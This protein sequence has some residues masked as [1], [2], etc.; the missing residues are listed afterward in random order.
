M[1]T[2][3]SSLPTCPFCD[4]QGLPILPVRYAVARTNLG[5]A[6]SLPPSFGQGVTDIALPGD[7]AKYTLRLLRPGFLYV[8]D[9][10][11][12]EWSA[13]VVNKQSYLWEFDIYAKT[14]PK[15]NNTIE[16]NA[17]CRGKSDPYVA[18]CFTVKRAARATKVWLGF[19]DVAWTQAVLAKHTS[20]DYRQ[21]NM[22]CI[23]IAAWRDGG[24]QPHVTSFDALPQVAE[25]AADGAALYWETR[26]HVMKFLPATHPLPE[27]ITA[28]NDTA[29][30]AFGTLS[31]YV[32][33]LLVGAVGTPHT[34]G[35]VNTAAWKFSPQQLHLSRE[36]T[37]PMTAWGNQSAKPYRPAI[38]GLADPVGI[39]MELNG[40]ALQ[41]GVEFLE[42]PE[43]R[44]QF[45]TVS[46]IDAIHHAVLN[47]AM[48]ERS[49]ANQA[50]A[51][52]TGLFVPHGL[53]RNAGY[54]ETI[55]HN[56]E[57]A[58][59]LSPEQKAALDQEAWP[60][61]EAQL[62]PV[63]W[64]DFKNKY[65]S[66]LQR[67][68]Q[69]IIAP[70]DEAYVAWLKSDG[71]TR[72]FTHNFDDADANHGLIY[73]RVVHAC[74]EQASGRRG[75][76]AYF[77]ECLG[78]DP[79]QP[80]Q[81]ILRAL[82]FNQQKLAMAL[83]QAAIERGNDVD[84]SWREVGEKFYNAVK[85][86]FIDISLGKDIH[87]PLSNL[88][89]LLYQLAGPVTS[90][91]GE[92][93]NDVANMAVSK[94]PERRV[95]ILMM[96]VLHAENPELELLD[97]RSMRSPRQAAK[98]LARAI[99]EVTGGGE[100]NLY[101]SAETLI[102]D[103]THSSQH[104]A[105]GLFLI[106]KRALASLQGADNATRLA[107]VRAETYEALQA[108]S[109]RTIFNAEVK[110][111][112]IGTLF[113][114]ASVIASYRDLVKS[115]DK[116]IKSM[117]FGTSVTAFLGVSMETSGH[118]LEKAP[119][120]E[121]IIQKL[122]TKIG[123][124]AEINAAKLVKL[125]KLLG[126]A[127]GVLAGVVEMWEGGAAWKYDKTYGL[128]MILL[129]IGGA[130]AAALVVFEAFALTGIGLALGLLVIAGTYCIQT[131]KPNEIQKWMARS[132]FGKLNKDQRYADVL[133]Q[134]NTLLKLA[135][136]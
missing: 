73:Q 45:E 42:E 55:H 75:A 110:A 47:G 66:D 28:Y 105:R 125:G 36:E 70:L 99:N 100:Q 116:T 118:L 51:M 106:D 38:V 15:V 25:F 82:I 17:A 56:L 57:Q 62:D 33:E 80:G 61:Y 49:D 92:A 89:K 5:N 65:P 78:N 24:M 129:G 35:L 79:T 96:G 12:N 132:R 7:I 52:A 50:A 115:E 124:N 108:Q 133:T 29:R 30:K 64:S 26:K 104:A 91:L 21:A 131:Y 136:G 34:S 14:P 128:G 74:I 119:W 120:A 121:S 44:W 68:D 126:V 22:Q 48:S 1:T 94:L 97:V 107:T 27:D 54:T 43:W 77:K 109:I 135:Q 59:L 98:A 69:T 87:G 111:C 3:A 93:L 23:D 10:H 6:P 58:R 84:R 20:A 112:M 83:A 16:F 88:S 41:S 31:P 19:S 117:R 8:Y 2:T 32:H 134:Q 123:I 95:M 60:K 127:G 72:S 76:A 86:T 71:F 90:R 67:L 39:A 46:A 113:A 40:L 114:A 130:T 63:A 81:V 53:V 18:R 11:R 37:A 85:N 102:R 101:K 122:I 103:E 4:K 13:F 9:E